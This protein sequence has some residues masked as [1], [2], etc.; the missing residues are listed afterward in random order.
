[1]EVVDGGQ[2]VDLELV[3]ARR[4]DRGDL[5]PV[6]G[7]EADLVGIRVIGGSDGADERRELDSRRRGG[8]LV[9]AVAASADRKCDDRQPNGKRQANRADASRLRTGG[10][11][12]AGS[13]AARRFAPVAAPTPSAGRAR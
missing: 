1:M 10:G 9:L 7:R 3:F 11:G 2:V 5:I 12:E 4:E 8:S 6:F 13:W